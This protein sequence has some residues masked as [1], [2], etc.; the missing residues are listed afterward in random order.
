MQLDASG[1][2]VCV[3]F[4]VL[5]AHMHILWDI[6][7]ECCAEVCMLCGYLFVS[8]VLGGSILCRCRVCHSY[9]VLT[10]SI[11]SPLPTF[12]PLAYLLLVRWSAPRSPVVP[13][14]VAS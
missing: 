2:G 4:L 13:L 3:C 14:R 9:L 1:R 8:Y 10:C 6:L 7:F 11:P 12:P 5:E